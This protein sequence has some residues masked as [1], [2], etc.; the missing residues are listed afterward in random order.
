MK[1]YIFI[2]LVFTQVSFAQ[3]NNTFNLGKN[4]IKFDVVS[5]VALGKIHVSYERFLGDDFSIGISGNFNQSKSREEDFER[6]KN[7]TL[8]E[9]Q[10]IPFVRY[11]LSKSQIRYYFVE[12]FVSANQGKYRELERLLDQNNNGYYEAV[13]KDYSDYA[14]ESLLDTNF[15]LKKN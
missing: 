12:V 6:G 5:I 8:E 4:E 13:Q 3:E 14:I 1:K 11:S 15:T 9:Y 7:R 10:I 2:F